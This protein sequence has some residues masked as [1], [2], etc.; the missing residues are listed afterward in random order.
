MY[1]VGLMAYNKQIM[2]I[3]IKHDKIKIGCLFTMN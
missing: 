1:A 2:I 3:T